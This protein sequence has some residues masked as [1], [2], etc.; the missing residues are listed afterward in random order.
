MRSVQLNNIRAILLNI[1]DP[2]GI[3]DINSVL[4]EYDSYL[5]PL[6]GLIADGAS[7]E[8]IA[9]ALAGYEKD[10]GLSPDMIRA[11]RA[12]KQLRLLRQ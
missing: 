3:A 2:I 6:C 7:A 1:W 8:A 11:H 4:D 12:A 10:M 5:S 9:A